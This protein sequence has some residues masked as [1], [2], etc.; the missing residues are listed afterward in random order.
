[1]KIFWIPLIL[2]ILPA[3]GQPAPAI[4]L[5]VW[6]EAHL[7]RQMLLKTGKEVVAI[8][9]RAGVGVS[10][11]ECVAGIADWTSKDPCFHQLPSYFQ[12]SI[13]AQKPPSTTPDK[14]GVTEVGGS[15]RVYYPTV[16]LR[17]RYFMMDAPQILGATIAHELGHLILGPNAH[18]PEG[19][20]RTDWG[21]DQFESIRTGRLEFSADQAKLMQMEVKRRLSEG[22]QRPQAG[23][24]Q[25]P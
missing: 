23:P 22:T 2:A 10:W 9:G 5:K 16:A 7:D 11:V 20:M 25:Q 3:A 14:A 19:V 15:A 24:G 4:T 21:P 18:T 12:V 8:L 13:T 6:N 1:M 17:A